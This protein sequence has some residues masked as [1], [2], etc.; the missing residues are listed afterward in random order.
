MQMANARTPDEKYILLFEAA[1]RSLLAAQVLFERLSDELTHLASDFSDGVDIQDH[2][3]PTLLSAVAFIDFAHRF[4]SIVNSL[5][6]INKSAPAVRRLRSALRTVGTARNHLQH[7]HGDLSS[8]VQIKYPVLGALSWTR[9][10]SCYV[11]F[12]NQATKAEA[13]SIA[14]DNQNRCWTAKHQYTVQDVAI[15]LDATLTEMQNAYRWL[16][17]EVSFSDP[18]F[19]SL[20]WGKAHFVRLSALPRSG[21]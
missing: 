13:S 14:Y 11:T 15:N 19:A 2:A 20:R 12:L 3:V 7:M 18:E 1:K 10:D 21:S 4:G 9:E 8:N 17:D 5:P 16:V 6:L